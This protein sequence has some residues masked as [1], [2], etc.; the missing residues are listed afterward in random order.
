MLAST[1]ASVAATGKTTHKWNSTL[2][3]ATLSTAGGY[4]NPGGTVFLAGALTARGL[5]VG[6]DLD[7]STITGHP[8][9]SVFTFKGKEVDFFAHGMER[10]SYAGTD[11][12]QADGSQV[13]V[14]AARFT[15]G[16]GRYRGASGHYT[17]KGTIPPGSSVLTG[18]S[19]GSIT[20]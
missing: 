3:E 20:Y 8:T 1:S 4:P 19:T 11:T 16:T 14:D 13:I 10:T 15:G 9:A 18:H 6:A 5:G 7:H 2:Q 17:F 12:V